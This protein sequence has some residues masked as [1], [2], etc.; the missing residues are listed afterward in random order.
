[1]PRGNGAPTL[2]IAVRGLPIRKK[3]CASPSAC[4]LLTRRSKRLNE[5][6][7]S[8]KVRARSS[9]SCST[10]RVGSTRIRTCKGYLG[11]ANV[12]R[13]ERQ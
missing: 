2:I 8:S 9:A 11:S 4:T 6:R 12:P 3:S 13:V 7:Y 10:P 5:P 1:M